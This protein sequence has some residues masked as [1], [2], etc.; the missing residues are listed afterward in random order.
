MFGRSLGGAVA[1][2]LTNSVSPGALILESTFSSLAEMA[3][4]PFPAFFVRLL[5]G[6]VWNSVRTAAALTVPT[7]CIHSPNDEIVPYR[8]GRRVYD[9]V[10]GDK[11]F[12]DIQGGHNTGFMESLAIYIPALDDF[13]TKHFGAK[14]AGAA[15]KDGNQ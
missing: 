6:D 8:Q 14:E 2:E 12:L 15:E 10:A 7:L 11:T 13:L 1:M 4:F 9:A 3:P 5:V